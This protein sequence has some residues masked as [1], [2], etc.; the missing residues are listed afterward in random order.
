MA[1]F[2]AQQWS[3][4]VHHTNSPYVF[5][6][7]WAVNFAL[8]CS[9]GRTLTYT[10]DV[11]NNTSKSPKHRPHYGQWIQWVRSFSFPGSTQVCDGFFSQD[12]RVQIIIHVR[13]GKKTTSHRGRPREAKRNERIHY[14]TAVS[15]DWL[16]VVCSARVIKIPQRWRPFN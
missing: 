6:Q 8:F 1:S 12:E 10:N 7:I 3:T 13:P 5:P 16:R 9:S 2:C 4:I 14:W 11:Q 15:R